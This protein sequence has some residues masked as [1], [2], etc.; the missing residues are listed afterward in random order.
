M[1]GPFTYTFTVIDRQRTSL[2]LGGIFYRVFSEKLFICPGRFWILLI[3][4]WTWA[5]NSPFGVR[6]RLPW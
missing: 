5:C 2:H 1:K 4:D 3:Y 6:F